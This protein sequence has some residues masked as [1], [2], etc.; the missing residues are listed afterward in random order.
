VTAGIAGLGY[1]VSDGAAEGLGKA[2][3][4]DGGGVVGV[5]CGL[6]VGVGDGFTALDGEGVQPAAAATTRLASRPNSLR[7]C[8]DTF[9]DLTDGLAERNALH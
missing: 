8:A 2:W 7:L 9:N 5:A 3:A 4:G 1:T 6:T